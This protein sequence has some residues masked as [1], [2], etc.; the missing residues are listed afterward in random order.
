LNQAQGRL[1]QVQVRSSHTN[2]V[3]LSMTK[4][5]K[6]KSGSTKAQVKLGQGYV[7]QLGLVYVRSG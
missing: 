1:G 7:I 6:G 5:F 4:S 2:Q 3:R